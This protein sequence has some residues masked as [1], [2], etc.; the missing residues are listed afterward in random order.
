MK[1]LFFVLFMLGMGMDRFSNA[2]SF[3]TQGERRY[4][5]VV[6]SQQGGSKVSVQGTV[7]F[8][9]PSVEEVVLAARAESGTATVDSS[10]RWGEFF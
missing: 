1:V 6:S 8:N 4:T 10:F 9:T 7:D 3:S 2:T 5:D